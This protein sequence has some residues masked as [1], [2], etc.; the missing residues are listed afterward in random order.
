MVE[1]DPDAESD[2]PTAEEITEIRQATPEE[3]SAVDELIISKCTSQWRKVAMVVGS[4][5]SEFDNRFPNLPYVYMP[6]RMLELERMGKIDVQ[7][8]VFSMRASEIRLHVGSE[9]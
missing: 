5:L 9:K 3:A 4:S 7:G 8:N 2:E 6:V 1:H